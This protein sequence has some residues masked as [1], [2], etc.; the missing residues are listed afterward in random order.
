VIELV[1]HLDDI[2]FKIACTTLTGETPPKSN[3]RDNGIERRT[4][5]KK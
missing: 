3:G 4:V 2:N 5:E 1:Q